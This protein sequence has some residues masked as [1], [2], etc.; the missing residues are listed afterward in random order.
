MSAVKYFPSLVAFYGQFNLYHALVIYGFWAFGCQKSLDLNE[1]RGSKPNM[2]AGISGKAC[3]VGQA[4]MRQK[5]PFG[6]PNDL[7]APKVLV[8]GCRVPV[9]HQSTKVRVLTKEEIKKR[10]NDEQI[11]AVNY[12]TEHLLFTAITIAAE[13]LEKPSFFKMPWDFEPQFKK[14]AEEIIRSIGLLDPSPGRIFRGVDD[15]SPTDLKEYINAFETN[16]PIQLG[17]KC[18]KW[19]SATRNPH[20]A[21]FYANRCSSTIR[22]AAVFVIDQKSARSIESISSDPSKAELLIPAETKFNITGI[23]P[24]E[25]KTQTVI[26]YLKEMD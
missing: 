14:T 20:V 22:Y 12:Y 11:R 4:K 3:R 18:V 2:N 24:V 23:W 8:E 13:G 5:Y 21:S 17:R 15:V 19:C 6:L 9:P 25:D 10:L 26:I 7:T 1:Y 16:K